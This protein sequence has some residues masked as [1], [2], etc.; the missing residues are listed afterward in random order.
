MDVYV[1]MYAELKM[2]GPDQT[3]QIGSLLPVTSANSMYEG[4]EGML[5]VY[6]CIS[7]HFFLLH[8]RHVSKIR[9]FAVSISVLHH[10]FIKAVGPR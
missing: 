8:Y 3:N 6:A 1:C 10:N 2:T 5:Y 7:K 9:Q 4:I